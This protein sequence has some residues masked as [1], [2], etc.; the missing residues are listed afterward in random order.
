MRGKTDNHP[1]AGGTYMRNILYAVV[2]ILPL[3]ACQ[4][5]SDLREANLDISTAQ[6]MYTVPSEGAVEVSFTV[7]NRGGTS[8]AVSRCGERVTAALDREEGGAWVQYSGDFCQAI[9]RMSPLPLAPG[10]TLES[11][12]MVGEPGRYRLRI[13][14]RSSPAAEEQ[15]MLTSDP[16]TVE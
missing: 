15:W 9:Y 13:G 12:R 1:V 8:A 6:T 10:E 3:A 11:V 16:F 2:L 5:I 14:V 7:T 4:S